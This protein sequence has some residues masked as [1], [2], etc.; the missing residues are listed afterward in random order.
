MLQDTDHLGLHPAVLDRLVERYLDD[1]RVLMEP[2][3]EELRW[4]RAHVLS[5]GGLSPRSTLVFYCKSGKHRSVAM[6]RMT[7]SVL[8]H[9]GATV[10]H[11]KWLRSPPRPTLLFS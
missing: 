7:A 11:F 2:L 5:D 3:A 4:R 8:R 6:A 9:L 10:P 1:V